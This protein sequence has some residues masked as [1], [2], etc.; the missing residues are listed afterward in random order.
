[1]RREAPLADSEQG[2]H[3]G[4]KAVEKG[5]NSPQIDLQETETALAA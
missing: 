3:V 1:M 2:G 5:G 4:R